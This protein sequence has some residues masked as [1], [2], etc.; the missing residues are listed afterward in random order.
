MPG[1]EVGDRVHNF[2]AQ[3][4]LSQ[5][6]HNSQAADGNWPVLSNSLWPGSQRQ[7]GFLNSGSKSYS[8]QQSDSERGPAGNPFHGSNGLTFTQSTTRPEFTKNQSQSQQPNFNGFMYGN[9]FYQMRQD[10]SNSPAVDTNSDQR[11]L[12]QR[13]ISAYGSQQVGGAENHGKSSARAETSGPPVGFDFFGAPQQM[14]H[15][16]LSMLQSMQH[17]PSGLNDM[18]Q[19]QQQVLL[20]KM[21]ELQRQQ[22]FSQIDAR[23]SLMNS[24][25]AKQASGSQSPALMNGSLNSDALSYQLPNDMGHSNWMQRNTLAMQGSSNGLVFSPNQGLAQRMVDLA[26]QQVEQSLYGVPVSNSRGSLNQYPHLATEKPSAQQMA[27]TGGFLPVNQYNALPGQGKLQDKGGTMGRQRYLAEN[28]FPHASGPAV[29]TTMDI[30]NVHQI[31]SIQRNAD[32]SSTS[33]RQE[34]PV[35]QNTVQEPANAQ[36]IT[37]REDVALDPTEERILFGSDDNIWA[38]FGKSTTMSADGSNLF[39]GAGLSGIS[40]IQSG[41]WSALMQSAVAETSSSDMGLQEEWSGLNFQNIDTASGNQHTPANDGKQHP[42][43]ADDNSPMASFGSGPVPTPGGSNINKNYQNNMGFQQFGRTFSND[44]SQRVPASTSQGLDLLSD[45][46]GKWSNGIPGRKSV[47]E[48]SQIPGN[49]SHSLDAETSGSRQLYN[50]PN[51]WNAFGT[52]TPYEDGSLSVQGRERSLQHSENTEQKQ[53]MQREVVEGGTLWK[54]SPGQES[55]VQLEQV[56]MSR[57]SSLMNKEGFSLNGAAV[58]SDSSNIKAAETSSQF[59]SNNHQLNYWKNVHSSVKSKVDEVGGSQQD[60]FGASMQ[61]GKEHEMENSD[62][63]E[64]SNDSYRS[65][66]SHHN[67]AGGAKDNTGSEVIESRALSTGKQKLSNQIARKNSSSR[68]FQYHPMGNLDDEGEHAQGMKQPTFPPAMSHFGQSKYLGQGQ[69]NDMQ[70]GTKGYNE[71][72]STNFSGSIPNHSIP[73]NK[74]VEM[75]SPDKASQSSQ[76]MLELLHKVDQS[77]EHGAL[78][79]GV[80][81][82]QNAAADT[83][84]GENSEGSIS[85]LQRS[86]SSNSQGFGLQL[87][88]PMQ[89]PPIGNQSLSSHSPMQMASS[90]QSSHAVAEIGQKGHGQLVPISSSQSVPS[91]R[92]RSQGENYRPGVSVPPAHVTSLYKVPGNLSAFNSGFPHSRGP[93]QSQEIAWASGPLSRSLDKHASAQKDDPHDKPPASQSM[94][95]SMPDEARSTPYGNSVS[96]VPPQN[97]VN[98]LPGRVLA[99]QFPAERPIPVSQ[100]SSVPNYPLVGTSSKPLP[101]MWTH[102]PAHQH[103]LVNEFQKVSSQNSQLNQTNVANSTSASLDQGDKDGKRGNISS[104]FSANA[105]NSENIR[106]EEERQENSGL[107]ESAENVDPGPKIKESQGKEPVVRTSSDGSPA[108]S[109]STQRDIEAFGRSLKPNN[110]LQQNF[111]LLNQMRPTKNAEDDPS[112]RVLKRMKGPDG[113]T[114][115]DPNMLNFSG[116]ETNMGANASQHGN[117]AAQGVLAFSRDGSHS[118][119]TTTSSKVDQL[120]I[121]P[122]MV[123]SWY[124]QFVNFRNGQIAPM[125]DAR[126]ATMLRTAEQPFNFGKSPAIMPTLNSMEPLSTANAVANQGREDTASAAVELY[127]SSASDQQPVILRSNKRKSCAS[128]LDP[129]HKEVSQGSRIFHTVSMADVEWARASNRLIDKVG[130]E[131]DLLE[132]GSLMVLKPKRRLILTTHLIQKLLRPPSAAFLSLDASLDYESA[133]YSVSR[134]ALGDACAM[135][136]STSSKSD[137]PLDS[138][139]RHSNDCGTSEKVGDQLLLKTIDGFMSRARTLENEFTRLDKRASVLDL[140]LECQDLEKFSVINRFAKFHGRGQAESTEASSSSDAASYTQKYLQR[141]VTALPLPRNLPTKVQCCSL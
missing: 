23:Q 132:D 45:Q 66:M 83:L 65:N 141:Y 63:Q 105:A 52:V 35:L 34:Q 6:Q 80:A 96:P 79:H 78:M 135:V 87:G 39:D 88:P 9:Q 54:S 31:N 60:K 125:Y 27:N 84:Q 81:S 101:N 50:K 21:Q 110:M 17:Q 94:Q 11:N 58:S 104:E 64:N 86:Q 134:L 115:V 3:D 46:G 47:A 56:K 15:Q 71:S 57:G 7:V 53:I 28:S 116:A 61:E 49:S 55:R 124:N 93:L 118:S 140:I 111:S 139:N 137:I 90:S 107:Q 25:F 109:L 113:Q 97:S 121:S 108:N 33:G 128:E 122:Q 32:M 48:G 13:T 73:F 69:S 114:P 127:P 119:S 123:P 82:D 2:F 59:I 12:S 20:M 95:T 5:G 44:S 120:K 62:K 42:H 1:N 36:N 51:G 136:T 70:R 30:G 16:Q 85:R 72:M 24:P 67:S 14:N 138:S 4:N 38:A 131:V 8:L 126:Q 74:S 10:E 40:S 37:S 100:P 75:F 41:S 130:D 99:Q 92:E 103:L 18:Q 117:L 19:L 76:N 98:I 89:R 77:K 133:V 43:L 112:N 106:S 68:K 91:S 102:V 22:Q 26:P 129:W 29:S